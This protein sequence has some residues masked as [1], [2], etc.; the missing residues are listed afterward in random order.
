MLVFYD[1]SKVSEITIRKALYWMSD[2]AEWSLDGEDETWRVEF[3]VS[4]QEQQQVKMK[5]EQLVNDYLLRENVDSNTLPL[6]NAIIQ[7]SLKDLSAR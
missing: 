6:K 3:A 1:K 5:L 2:S 4:V 7:K